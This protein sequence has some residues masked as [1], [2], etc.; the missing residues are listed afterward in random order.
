MLVACIYPNG[1]VVL[2][3]QG[4]PRCC[5]AVIFL[6]MMVSWLNISPD[7]GFQFLE[8]YSGAGRITQLAGHVGYESVAYDMKYGLA[9]ANAKNA[10]S[11]MDINSNAG[12][13]SLGHANDVMM[14]VRYRGHMGLFLLLRCN[15]G[16]P[17][18][19]LRKGIKLA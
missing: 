3:F 8:F 6:A 17:K 2:E 9:R 14:Y 12:L 1:Y 10:R 11:A 19:V 15:L 7:S 16:N 13:T 5:Q 18:D 4:M